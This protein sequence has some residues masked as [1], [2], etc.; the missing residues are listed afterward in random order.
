MPATE[1]IDFEREFAELVRELRELPTAAP[2]P[3][4]A[5][6]RA[7]GEPAPRREL[8]RVP[9]R[10]SLLV[11]APACVLAVLSAAVVHGVLSSGPA[12]QH[13]VL[14]DNA[15]HGAAGGS[16]RTPPVFE[17][18]VVPPAAGRRQDYE[19]SMTL[20]VKDLDALTDRTNE[21]MRVVRSYGG[22]VASVE[23]STQAGRPGEADLVLRV[24][25]GRVED[26][27]VQLSNLG[28]VL[29]RQ[30]SIVDLEHALAQQRARILR[31]KVFIA[32]ATAELKTDLPADVRLRLQLQLQQAR[33]DLAQAT[34]A[35]KGTLD[36]AAF[37]HVSLALT[38]QQPASAVARGHSGRFERAARNAGLF[39]A[40][41]GAVIL[42][43]VIVLSPLIALAVGWRAYRRRE[44]RRLLAAH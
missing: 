42:F 15:V 10:R 18:G 43:L 30:V 9:W 32:R 2:E 27:L 4:R 11:L 31:L 29:A 26:A 33:Q 35:N 41:A 7:L 28:T 44:E 14:Q 23:Q 34:R 8:P 3:V 40:R 39:L 13:V 6:V 1:T 19:A 21:A 20:R 17:A 36:Q 37:S 16:V 5:R 25:V 22:Y 38:T 12:K 24:P